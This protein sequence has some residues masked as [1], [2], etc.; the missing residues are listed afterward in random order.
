LI[1]WYL[2]ES[3]I[4]EEPTQQLTYNL[5]NYNGLPVFFSDRSVPIFQNIEFNF[6][7]LR[8]QELVKITG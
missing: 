8:Y 3:A 7:E 2:K 6:L 1:N 4:E 5:T